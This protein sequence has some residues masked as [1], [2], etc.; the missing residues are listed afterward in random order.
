MA[1]RAMD[2]YDAYNQNRLPKDHGYI[3]SSFFSPSS[4]YSIYEIVS[5]AA[6]KSFYL[7]GS[8]ITFQTNGKKLY[9]LVEPSDYS[10]K[11]VEPYVRSSKD[12]IPLRFSDLNIYT[13]KNQYRIMYN[14]VPQEVMT[15]FTI[16]KPEGM[17]FAFIFYMIP[18]VYDILALFFEKTFNREANVP[19][20]DSKK[21]AKLISS[22]IHD[23]MEVKLS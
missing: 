14:K 4:A 9:I 15:S 8:G 17:N 20:T 21:L 6:V 3:V 1:T 11:A 12:Q 16:L 19:L 5:Y 18:E 23:T 22:A 7:T 10:Q 13:A 2:L